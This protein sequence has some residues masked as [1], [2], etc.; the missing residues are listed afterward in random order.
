MTAPLTA[1]SK[2]E[3]LAAFIKAQGVV[4]TS[5]IIRWG[6]EN[7]FNRA[8]RTKGQLHHDGLIRELTKEEKLLRG[9]TSKESAYCWVGEPVVEPSGQLA[10]AP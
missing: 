1:P 2:Q 8:N 6:L 5:Q 7:Y 10:F 9:I 3:Q 4:R